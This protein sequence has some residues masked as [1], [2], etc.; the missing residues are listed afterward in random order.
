[1]AG[2]DIYLLSLLI[3]GILKLLSNLHLDLFTHEMNRV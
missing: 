2:I 1:M 3:L